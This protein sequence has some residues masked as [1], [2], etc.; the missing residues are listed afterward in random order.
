MHK[1]ISLSCPVCGQI[2]SNSIGKY[3]GTIY[4]FKIENGSL[5][6]CANCSMVYLEQ[7]PT[8]EQL[9]RFYAS[10]WESNDSVQS[11]T[12]DSLQLYKVQSL[13]RLLFLLDKVGSLE[14]KTILDFGAGHG[15][16]GEAIKE[17]HINTEYFAVEAD[18][19]IVADLKRQGVNAATKIDDLKRKEF[20]IIVLFHVL[21]HVTDPKSL[22]SFLLTH[23]SKNGILFIESPNKDY[24]F[25]ANYQPHTLFFNERALGCLFKNIGM[26]DFSIYCFGRDLASIPHERERRFSISWLVSRVKNRIHIILSKLRNNDF[27]W[28]CKEY[29]LNNFGP[30]RQWLRAIIKKSS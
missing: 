2:S 14:N 27:D 12:N 30:D 16:F 5:S 15:L 7:M 21:E 4:P 3:L 1:N 11:S 19:K 23:L 13:S 17:R 28:Y 10:Y 26:T 9:D 6:E 18:E 29:E 24:L 20:D 25:K 22:L 8:D